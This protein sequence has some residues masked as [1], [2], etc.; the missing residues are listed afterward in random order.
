MRDLDSIKQAVMVTLTEEFDHL[1]IL[2]VQIHE[3]RDVDGDDVLRI[4]VIFEGAPKDLDAKKLSGI[5]R[6]LRPRLNAIQEFAIPL[7]SFIS[8]ADLRNH[9]RATA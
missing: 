3:D 2:D 4:N 5:I 9:R 6:H 7:L 8:R 1:R